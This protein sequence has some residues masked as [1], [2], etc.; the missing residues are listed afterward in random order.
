MVWAALTGYNLSMDYTQLSWFSIL[1]GVSAALGLWWS[2][3]RMGEDPRRFAGS[4]IQSRRSVLIPA[5]FVLLAGGLIGA[6]IAFVFL[7]WS[8]YQFHTPEIGRVWEGG[9]DWTGAPLGAAILFLLFAG[10]KNLSPIEICEDL[11][12]LWLI[13]VTALWVGCGFS[14]MYYG[15][16]LPSVRWL[17]ALVDVSGEFAPRL[18]LAW[19]GVLV[20]ILTGILADWLAD[21]RKIRIFHFGWMFA[22]QMGMLL[23]FSFVR[24]DPVAPLGGVASDRLAAGVYLG[25]ILVLLA[26]QWFQRHRRSR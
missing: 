3:W 23:W 4:S 16:S 19:I 10:W 14:G 17:P 24:V 20:T 12:P 11:A 15:I 8:Y 21:H 25:V 6:R 9:L 18:P 1:V 22:V 2:W 5:A 7:H 13:L 26:V